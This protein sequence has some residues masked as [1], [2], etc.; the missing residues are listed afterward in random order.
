MQPS[1]LQVEFTVYEA[2]LKKIKADSKKVITT[3]KTAEKKKEKQ[4]KKIRQLEAKKKKTL[5][6]SCLT[7]HTSSLT[8]GIHTPQ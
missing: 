4:A 7:P 5:A 8:P 1:T 2:D 3:A 6:L